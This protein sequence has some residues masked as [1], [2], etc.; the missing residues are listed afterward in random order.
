MSFYDATLC[1]PREPFATSR[2]EGFQ[3]MKTKKKLTTELHPH[4]VEVR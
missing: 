1:H 3:M 4:A 2:E